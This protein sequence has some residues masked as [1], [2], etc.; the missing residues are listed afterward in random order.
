[1]ISIT[2]V[3]KCEM[4]HDY[5]WIFEKCGRESSHKL[6]H[7]DYGFSEVTYNN[8]NYLIPEELSFHPAYPRELIL[9]THLAQTEEHDH[10]H[11]EHTL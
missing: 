10:S 8:Q 5:K 3:R 9:C 6:A 4:G 11:P 2:E 7:G 1:M